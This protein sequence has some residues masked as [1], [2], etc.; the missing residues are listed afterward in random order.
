MDRVRV[1]LANM[2]P[3]HGQRRATLAAIAVVVIGLLAVLPFAANPVPKVAAFIPALDAII[4]T[5]DFITACLFLTHF[6]ITRSRAL[7][8]LGCGYLFSSLII[9]VH[10]LTFPGVITETGNLFGGTHTNFRIYLLWHLGLP[11]ALIAY[12][13]LRDA[14][15]EEA[16]TS[17]SIEISAIFVTV[18]A[19]AV[20][21][22]I[23]CLALL[24]AVNPVAGR[25]LTGTTILICA[26]AL[27]MLWIAQRSRLDQWLIVV[28]CAMIAELVITALVGGLGPRAVSVGFYAGRVFSLVTSTAVLVALL[29]ETARLYAG[30]ARGNILASLVNASQ[31]LSREIELPRLAERILQTAMAYTE[32]DE[33]VLLLPDGDEL[34]IRAI[35]RVSDGETKVVTCRDPMTDLSC[36]ASIIGDV[37]H[38][39]KTVTIDDAA[40]TA[41]ADDRYLQHRRPRAALCMPLMHHDVLQG[42]LYLESKQRQ[43]VFNGERARLLE[44]LASQAAISL[45]NANLYSSLREREARLRRLIDAN[46][47]GIFTWTLDGR[48]IDANDAF[49]S[50]VGYEREDLASDRMRWK[51]LMPGDWDPAN[52]PILEEML[53]SG[54]T[55]PFRARYVRKD[56]G[57]VPVLV[58][59]AL[60][61]GT[62]TEGVAFVVDMTDQSRAE[63][64]IR[65]R[66]R[67]YREMELELAHANR[68]A[69]MGHL[70][71][72]IAHE[73]NQPLQGIVTNSQTAARLLDRENPKLDEVKKIIARLMRDGARA[74]EVISR[75]RTLIKKAPPQKEQFNINE[76]I[77]DIVELLHAEASRYGASISTRLEPRLPPVAGDRVQLQQVVLNL[78]MNAL[79]A[80]RE[81][82][83]GPR[84]ILI[85]TEWL[86]ASHIRVSVL[87]SGSGIAGDN[88]ERIFDPF[89][90]TKSQGLGMGLSICRSIVDAHG[91]KLWAA[92]NS[93]RG[94]TL[95]FALPVA[96]T[97]RSGESSR[98]D[99]AGVTRAD[100]DPVSA[101][102]LGSDGKKSA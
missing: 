52:D 57:L 13:L 29:G 51:D 31:S 90:T 81:I 99:R 8:M 94:A 39:K 20:L 70:S 19:L 24:P 75:I 91:G 50:I 6:Q 77:I 7:A 87:D 65:D 21:S 79:D 18:G 35:V 36:P 55:P 48:I 9:V 34:S 60:F 43:G 83:I 95:C 38:L 93:P 89:Y 49:L 98:A 100:P 17:A 3:T 30:V 27:A 66:E 97:L 45:E 101:G 85:S 25:W 33:G 16:V 23:A 41:Y 40:A 5:T 92:P 69:T 80:V 44:L 71:A 4:F 26:I 73:L 2:P 59:A 28:M 67:Q 96:E 76:A 42:L 1:S 14:R 47:V 62:P 37:M 72:S 86:D 11:V 22:C 32:A 15:R 88:I 64:M 102:T 84:R 63:D 82:N 56:G 61:D 74:G 78:I 10:G 46:I 54:A 58:G 68:L 53:A 12:L